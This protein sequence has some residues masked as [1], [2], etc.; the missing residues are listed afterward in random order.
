MQPNPNLTPNLFDT[1]SGILGGSA[2][3]LILLGFGIIVLM[4]ILFPVVVCSQLSRMNR[5]L[6]SIRANA[7]AL[8]NRA[9]DY[10]AEKRRGA[11]AEK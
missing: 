9:G 4:W 6:E 5:T 8:D 7:A 10:I 11:R 2:F 1:L 3:G